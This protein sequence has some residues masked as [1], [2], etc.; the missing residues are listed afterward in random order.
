MRRLRDLLRSLLP[1]RRMARR[2]TASLVRVWPDDPAR[3]SLMLLYFNQ[4]P[5][6]RAQCMAQ[7]CFE[8]V[9]GDTGKHYRLGPDLGPSVL[10]LDQSGRPIVKLGFYP[11]GTLPA[12]DTMLAQ[13]I[14]LELFE[15]DV[16]RI[17]CRNR[18]AS[19]Y[20]GGY[21]DPF[22]MERYARGG[23]G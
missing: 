21:D 11:S 20:P 10:E 17:A 19:G 3:R 18:V 8:V 15:H 2:R 6:Q 1:R 16:L 23:A 5:A 14:A 22:E 12:G 4:T 9:G 13:K 7:R